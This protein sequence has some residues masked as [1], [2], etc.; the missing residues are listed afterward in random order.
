VG[1]AINEFTSYVKVEISGLTKNVLF[2][3][4]CS[5]SLISIDLVR[6]I[7]AKLQPL[8]TS[9]TSFKIGISGATMHCLG[10]IGVNVLLYEISV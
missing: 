5:K 1:A 9:D 10:K 8:E 3:S 2:D 6:R 7:H 4:G